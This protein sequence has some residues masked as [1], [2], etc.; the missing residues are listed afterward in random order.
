[1][2]A[3]KIIV[4][5]L[6]I[7][8]SVLLDGWALTILWDWFIAGLFEL[9]VLTLGAAI[10]VSLVV[11]YLTYQRDD[12]AGSGNDDDDSNSKMV[13]VIIYAICKPFLALLFGYIVIC[14][15]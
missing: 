4:V 5:L 8:I 3:I 6:M 12:N 9:P 2:T 15:M 11:K 1:M 10:G 7:P 13:K 14:C